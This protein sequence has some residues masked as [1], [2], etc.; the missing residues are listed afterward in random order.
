MGP[1]D[2]FNQEPSGEW[3]ACVKPEVQAVLMKQSPKRVGEML[4][5]ITQSELANSAI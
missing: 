3:L 2:K 4:E 5:I 1:M